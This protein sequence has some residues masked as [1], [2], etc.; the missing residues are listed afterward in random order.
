MELKD[1]LKMCRQRLDIS[2]VEVA[3]R[4]KM[5]HSIYCRVEKGVIKNTS[6]INDLANIFNV[7]V[8]WL[9]TGEGFESEKDIYSNETHKNN[10]PILLGNEIIKWCMN[11]LKEKD[12]MKPSRKFIFSPYNFSH[13]K[14]KFAI[15]VNDES[16]SCQDG[17]SFYKGSK[18]II[19]PDRQYQDRDYIMVIES[20]GKPY[21]AQFEVRGIVQLLKPINPR[22]HIIEELTDSFSVIGVIVAHTSI[23]YDS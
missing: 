5:E 20:T 13:R 11:E 18:V 21:L 12:I 17:L 16:M 6:H 22:Y 19:D 15:E 23:F 3:K 10:I 8:N 1:R 2:Q 9:L 14:R 4:A 7:D